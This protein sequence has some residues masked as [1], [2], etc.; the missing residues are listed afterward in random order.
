MVRSK[1]QVVENQIAARGE[2]KSL[3][4]SLV[5]V[6]MRFF[7]QARAGLAISGCTVELDFISRRNGKGVAINHFLASTVGNLR[8]ISLARG[9]GERGLGIVSAGGSRFDRNTR[10]RF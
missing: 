2:R 7:M 9:F 5:L 1:V 8:N 4:C 6:R 10:N 3:F